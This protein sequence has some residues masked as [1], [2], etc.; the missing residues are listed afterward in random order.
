MQPSLNTWAVLLLFAAAQGFFLALV[1]LT[2]RRGNRRANIVL[3]ILVLLIALRLVETVGYWT[4]YLGLFPHFWLSTASFSFLFGPLLYFYAKFLAGANSGPRKKDGWHL[5]PFLCYLAWLTRFYRLPLE[6]KLEILEKYIAVENP[7]LEWP[8]FVIFLAQILHMLSYTWLTLRLLNARARSLKE[9]SSSIESISL[10]WLK[11]LTLGFGGCVLLT[12]LYMAALQW[13]LAYSRAIDALVL[14]SLA[15]LIY[16][17]SYVGL[18]HP[19]IFS[20]VLAV[21]NV[22]KYEKSTLTPARASAYVSKLLH[23]MESERLFARSEL[24]LQ[25]LAHQL[26][27]SPHHLSQIINERLGQNFFEFINHYRV[28]E[29]QKLLIDPQKQQFTILSLALEVGFNN[30]ASFNAAFKKHTGMT[31]SQFRD[32]HVKTDKI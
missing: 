4:K 12:F 29:A 28:A 17:I 19:E 32:T 20:G 7:R 21:K 15:A 14:L 27:I 3:A 1:L 18:R 23:L 10:N 25:D 24:K 8:Y 30:K 5:L 16:A 6:I 2:H 26:D 22:P 9:T 31:P 13:G 11:R